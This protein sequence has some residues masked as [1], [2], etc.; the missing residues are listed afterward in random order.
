M[1]ALASDDEDD[2]LVKMPV[3]LAEVVSPSSKLTDNGDK[4]VEY[5]SMSSTAYYLIIH[6]DEILVKFYR[7]NGDVWEFLY[8][9]KP[10]DVIQLP[11]LKTKIKLSEI[12]KKVDF[13]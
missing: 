3:L 7:R 4:L 1:V 12:Y 9:N 2:Y 6:Q 5:T 8:Y 10:S 13:A 11:A